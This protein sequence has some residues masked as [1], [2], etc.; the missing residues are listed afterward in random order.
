MRLS[1]QLGRSQS[2]P[3]TGD[4]R[5]K[6]AKTMRLA[7]RRDRSQSRSRCLYAS[8]MVWYGMVM[9]WYGVVQSI[10]YGTVWYG[11]VWYGHGMV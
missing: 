5:K 9:V 7:Q 4:A 2:R 11:V 8:G 3:C 1:Q 6:Q 10:W